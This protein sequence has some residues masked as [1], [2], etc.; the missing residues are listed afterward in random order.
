MKRLKKCQWFYLKHC[1]QRTPEIVEITTRHFFVFEVEAA[2]ED[3]HAQ[4]RED[5]DEEGEED[6]QAGNG[7]DT[8]HQRFH[9]V[10][11][12]FPVARHFEDAKQ[13]DTTQHTD[14]DRVDAGRDRNRNL[15]KTTQHNLQVRKNH[16]IKSHDMIWKF[17]DQK[18]SKG[19]SN[20]HVIIK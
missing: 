15:Q 18:R 13:S 16:C 11:Q 17:K 5:E 10:A 1:D 4:Q 8:V 14:P 7:L 20:K 12:R 3:L 9:Q 6:Q 2:A 19:Q